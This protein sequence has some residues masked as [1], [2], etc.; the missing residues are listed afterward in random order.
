MKPS[1]LLIALLAVMAA[2]V[3]PPTSTPSPTATL[4]PTPTIQVH[5]ST[6]LFQV[7]ILSPV[8][9]CIAGNEFISG[10][11]CRGNQCG[12][13]ECS[14]QDFDPPVPIVSIRPNQL[15]Q[16]PYNTYRYRECFDITLTEDEISDIRADMALV[17]SKASEWTEGALNLTMDIQVLPLV[18]TSFAAPE[19]VFGPFEVD[20]ELLN[21]YITRDTDFI[22][23]VTGVYDRTQGVNLAYL[24]GGSYGEMGIHGA[25]FSSIQYNDICNSVTIAGQTVYEPLIHEWM[26]SLDWALYNVNGV[27][28]IYEG[29]AVNWANWDH[30][31]WPACKGGAM[32]TYA[33]FPSVDYCEWDPDWM[34]CNNQQSAGACLHAGEVNSLPS[35]YE[36]VLSEHYPRSIAFIG[37]ACRNGKQDWGESGID[38]G[39]VCP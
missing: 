14:T 15:D 10:S 16:P 17:A 38:S 27:K 22:Y 32:N 2:C 9:V 18:S 19:F 4:I 21:P 6:A 30:A 29:K 8:T 36:H 12:D 3:P 7:F 31:T 37:N 20:D 26:H 13:C 28:D 34:D 24:C 11:V 23:V 33:W 39:G 5:A 25:N 1:R 35:W